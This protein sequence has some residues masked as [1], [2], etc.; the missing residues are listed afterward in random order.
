MPRPKKTRRTQ[1]V[2]KASRRKQKKKHILFRPILNFARHHVYITAIV[3]LLC[4]LGLIDATYTLTTRVFPQIPDN[5]AIRIDTYFSKRNMP[6]AGHG[7]TF[8]AVADACEMDWRL[9]PAIAVR[10]SSGGKRM[11]NNNPFGWGGA[12][13]PFES[14]EHAIEEVGR[15]LCGQNPRTARWYSTSST[16]QKLY[17]YN[18][19]VISSYPA[20]VQWIMKQF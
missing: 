6:L 20:E 17:Y 12:M 16:R 8:V 3:I 5:R 13:I 14:L 4:S 19:T 18:G 2:K 1:K 9:L 15:N 7:E 10:E 11:M